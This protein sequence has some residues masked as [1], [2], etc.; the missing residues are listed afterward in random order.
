MMALRSEDTEENNALNSQNRETERENGEDRNSQ[1]GE[2]CSR[3]LRY[4][5]RG[6]MFVIVLACATLSKL[7]LVLLTDKLRMLTVGEKKMESNQSRDGERVSH[8]IFICM[9]CVEFISH[10]RQLHV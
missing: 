3:T 9:A 7:T 4:V 1:G 8:A 6:V 5:Q 2:Y 10:Q